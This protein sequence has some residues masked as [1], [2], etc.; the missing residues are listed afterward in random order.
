MQYNVDE[1][2]GPSFALEDLVEIADRRKAW[3]ALGA[4]VGLALG[5]V[6]FLVLPAEYSATTTLLV[7][8]QEVPEHFVRTTITVTA[9][10]RLSTL[11]ERV[12]SYS[13]L[14]ELIDRLGEDRLD[15]SGE[16]TREA[17]MNQIRGS[18]Q[19]S[20]KGKFN[21]D[22]TGVFVVAYSGE[23]PELVAEAAREIAALFISENLKDR[24]RQVTAT[25][26][27]L[28]RE[29]EGLRD[30]VTKKEDEMRIFKEERMGELPSQLDAN[31][32]ALDRMTAQIARNLESQTQLNARMELYRQELANSGIGSTG[33][34]LIK[35]LEHSRNQL[36]KAESIY[37]EEHPNVRH[38]QGEID[39]IESEIRK[40]QELGPGEEGAFADAGMSIAMRG[41]SGQYGRMNLEMEKLLREEE[42]LRSEIEEYESRVEMAPRLEQ[43]LISMTRDYQNLTGTYRRLLGQKFDAEL[44]RNLEH[45]QKGER[46][47][48]LQPARVPREPSWPDIWLLLPGG[49][50]VALGFVGLLIVIAELRNPAFR[51]V[52]RLTRTT[53]LPVV[54]SVPRIDRDD[55]YDEP[56]NGDV[57]A[58][59]VVHC[60]PESAPAEQYR[61][62][63]PMFLED[64]ERRVVLVTSAARGD[65]K[66]LT[67]MNLAITVACDL[68]KKVLVIDGDLRRPTTHRLL[69]IR[70]SKGLTDILLG[71]LPLEECAVNSKIP[72]L[73]LLPAGRP[74]KNPLALITDQAFLDLLEEAKKHYDAIFI[75]SP[76]LLPVVDTRILKRMADLVL[77]VV[78]ADSTPRA[79]AMRSMADLRNVA[80]VVFNQVSPGSFRRYYYHDAYARYAY[81]DPSGNETAAEGDSRA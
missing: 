33:N 12:T 55:I 26:D 39:R 37:T 60:A 68:N 63:A 67:C 48:V 79:A 29:L 3:M 78:R 50:A 52:Q 13:N 2:P 21:K 18:L 4:V 44:A 22:A 36:L 34:R 9:Q 46:F 43:E 77:F 66:S 64:P 49:L 24:A 38:W 17:L 70:R 7:E 6:A 10:Q 15:P 81:G 30:E 54:A 58:R 35:A 40:A 65:G 73:S 53:G 56:P 27:F 8:P 51:T 20:T 16:L 72:N 5:F 23:S 25:A 57:D 71:Q 61:G 31:L 14:N 59:L 45:A 75:D 74:A 1:T 69:K 42:S 41:V 47:R 80:G 11:K 76:P 19:V 28:D 62:F 32:R